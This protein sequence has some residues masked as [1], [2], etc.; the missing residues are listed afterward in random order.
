MWY[1]FSIRK[2]KFV[3][4]PFLLNVFKERIGLALYAIYHIKKLLY[5][6]RYQS[7]DKDQV[8]FDQ[9]WYNIILCTRHKEYVNN[10]L[11]NV[12]IY[13]CFFS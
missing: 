6:F 10:V 1:Y 2:Y 7:N 3:N 11:I 13:I 8:K 9:L 4:N 12:F 5:F